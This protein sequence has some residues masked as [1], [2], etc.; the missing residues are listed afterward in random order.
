MCANGKM[1]KNLSEK[2]PCDRWVQKKKSK[3]CTKSMITCKSLYIFI[4]NNNHHHNHPHHHHHHQ[5]HFMSCIVVLAFS[6]QFSRSQ[7]IKMFL[8]QFCNRWFTNIPLLVYTKNV[9]PTPDHYN[10]RSHYSFLEP[11]QAT[12]MLTPSWRKGR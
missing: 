2:L 12:Q 7:R 4:N 5:H 9:L 8:G 1:E 6:H 10:S 11:R 3:A